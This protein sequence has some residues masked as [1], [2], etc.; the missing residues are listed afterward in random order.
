MLHTNPISA[1]PP[2]WFNGKLIP[3]E[4]AK[5]S[6]FDHGLLYG[7]G[8]F[9]GMRFFNRKVFKANEHLTRLSDSLQ[10]I[11]LLI[12]YTQ[13]ELRE[14]I[15]T[16]VDAFSDNQGYLRLVI[17][18]GDGSLGLNPNTCPCPNVFIIASQLEMVNE[19]QREKGIA[20]ITS[21]IRRQVGTGLDA[22][23]KSLNYLHSIM[24]KMEANHAG[25]EEAIL[26]NQQG[27]VAECCAENIFV[28][29]ND[30]LFTPPVSDGALAG[31]TRKTVMM[32]AVEAGLDVSEQSLTTYDVYTADECFLTGS[33]ARLIPVREVDG[34]T[35][36]HCPGPIYQI[37]NQ[38]YQQLSKQECL[39]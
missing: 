18:R 1:N 5:V 32:L 14:G 38:A 31:I 7:D 13:D 36:A 27:Y 37:I 20:L 6:V 25:V 33:G 28:V 19:Q 34:R 23:V 39:A 8:V 22:R 4:N 29:K 16:C 35:L 30:V 24:A 15:Q 3:T 12:P 21:S 26:L 17:T 10:A 9:E 2:I 11:G